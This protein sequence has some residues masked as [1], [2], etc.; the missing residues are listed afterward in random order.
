MVHLAV[1]PAGFPTGS[2]RVSGLGIILSGRIFIDIMGSRR[3]CFPLPA[4]D[5]DTST[6]A[7]TPWHTHHVASLL[8]AAGLEGAV[9]EAQSPTLSVFKKVCKSPTPFPYPGWC[10][11]P[12]SGAGELL[13]TADWEQKKGECFPRGAWLTGNGCSLQLGSQRAGQCPAERFL[14]NP[15][16]YMCLLQEP[17]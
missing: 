1:M 12:V 10:S 16:P 11:A 3:L 5:T 8:F 13:A 4:Q 7:V 6:G 14:P 2:V 17:L 15:F 9:A